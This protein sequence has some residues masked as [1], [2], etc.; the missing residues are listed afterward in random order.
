MPTYTSKVTKDDK[1]L[2]NPGWGEE[3]CF[4]PAFKL[5]YSSGSAGMPVCK[6]HFKML[7]KEY[8]TKLK[9]RKGEKEEA[10]Y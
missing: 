8:G 1:C 2:W 6:K 7:Q 3:V 9:A 10:P 5:F 4:K